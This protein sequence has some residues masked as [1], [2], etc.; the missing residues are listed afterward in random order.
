MAAI[1][2]DLDGVIYKG[3]KLIEG[4]NEAVCW[5]QDQKIPHVF[6]TNTTSRPR[7]AIVDKLAK[8]GIQTDISKIVTPPVVAYQYLKE[9]V[10]GKVALFLKQ[11]TK[12][13]FKG[14]D[15]LDDN[16]ES[17][18]DAIV[19][20]D[21]GDHWDYKKLNR[22]FRL[23]MA[24]SKPELIALG[25]TRYWMAPDGL[26][27]DVAPFI[28]ALEHA[29]NVKAHVC[30]KPAAHFF[31]HA[32]NLVNESPLKTIMIGDDIRVDIGGAHNVGMQGILVKTGKFKSSD[33][34]R[35]IKPLTVLNSISDLPNWWLKNIITK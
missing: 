23:L 17:D 4:A 24:D 21:L 6:L 3:D 27:L 29:S 26:R 22:A 16:S 18:A 1:L 28:I 12:E 35:G 30:G 7:T 9:N 14:L 13:E 31:V 10:K 32:L 15:L 5:F 2:F 25:M 20:G 33:L 34:E 11:E 8:F 19:I